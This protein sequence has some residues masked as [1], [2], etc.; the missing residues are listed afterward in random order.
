MP[1]LRAGSAPDGIDLRVLPCGP[2]PPLNYVLSIPGKDVDQ[3]LGFYAVDA[4]RR[5]SQLLT[6]ALDQALNVGGFDQ[7]IIN[8]LP[9]GLKRGFKCGIAGK[10]QSD[11]IR[12]GA[13]HGAD[14]SE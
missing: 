8:L 10:D 9:D 12:L 6:N 14:N 2:E 5:R 1:S 13:A 3:P 7:I 11:S 4:W